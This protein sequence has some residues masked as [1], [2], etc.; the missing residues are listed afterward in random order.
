MPSEGK[1][2]CLVLSDNLLQH[3]HNAETR[4]HCPRGF[5]SLESQCRDDGSE[6][7]TCFGIEKSHTTHQF[8]KAT[9]IV[10]TTNVTCVPEWCTC[11]ACATMSH[12]DLQVTV[13]KA[14]SQSNNDS[15]D[16]KR[17][18]CCQMFRMH[19][20]CHHDVQSQ[21]VQ[22]RACLAGNAS[23]SACSSFFHSE[24]VT[25]LMCLPTASV[26]KHNRPSLKL[27]ASCEQSQTSCL[28]CYV[29][30]HE[31]NV[32]RQMQQQSARGNVMQCGR[33]SHALCMSGS[34]HT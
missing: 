28:V 23:L 25:L 6:S 27:E 1:K 34:A 33:L 24:V 31:T 15:S 9:W 7:K 14:A 29:S 22:R 26:T 17:D 13:C 8:H 32:H 12:A 18:N 11:T 5:C 21:D 30:K 2:S 19:S 3:L 10:L 20:L 4:C 16:Y